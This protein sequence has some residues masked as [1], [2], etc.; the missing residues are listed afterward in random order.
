MLEQIGRVVSIHKEFAVVQ[1]QRTSACQHCASTEN[2]GTAAL[3]QWWGQRKTAVPRFGKENVGI[4]QLTNSE[5]IA[6]N[7]VSARVG[8]TVTLG[9][10]EQ[11]L[12]KA[13]LTVYLF[14]LLGMFLGI[15]GYQIPVN[16]FHFPHHELLNLLS[17]ALGFAFVLLIL[18]YRAPKLLTCDLPVILNIIDHPQQLIKR[19]T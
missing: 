19:Q 11:T 10:S 5:V 17:G 14:P 3:A 15:I 7:R 4:L 12:L 2:C 1:T 18:K 13:A 16:Y 6:L 9:L 8:Q